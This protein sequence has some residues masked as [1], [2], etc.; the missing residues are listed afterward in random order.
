MDIETKTAIGV[1]IIAILGLMFLWPDELGVV[2]AVQ[3]PLEQQIVLLNQQHKMELKVQEA[4]WKERISS[5]DAGL[6]YYKAIANDRQEQL[7]RL[8]G[9]TQ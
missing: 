7:E 5:C 3:L 4:Q 6:G 8:R 2:E 1:L 9:E